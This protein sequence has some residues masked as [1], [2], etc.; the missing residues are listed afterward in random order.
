MEIEFS[1]RGATSIKRVKLR[2]RGWG[3]DCTC[4]SEEEKDKTIND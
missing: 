3:W 4:R 1:K 2:G